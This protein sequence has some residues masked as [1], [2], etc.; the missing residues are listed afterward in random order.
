MEDDH[1]LDPP[2]GQGACFELTLPLLEKQGSKLKE[3]SAETDL[4]EMELKAEVFHV[5][6][7]ASR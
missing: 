6:N 4:P 3:P 7:I 5:E 1:E 2:S